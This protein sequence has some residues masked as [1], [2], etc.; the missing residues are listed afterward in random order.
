MSVRGR[1]LRACLFLLTF[2]AAMSLACRRPPALLRVTFL[3]VGQGDATVIE[4]PSGRVLLVDGG[5]VPGTQETA[6][7][8]P[9]VR[10][11]VPF[12]RHR[13]I[14]T[15]DL[16]VA[17]HPDDDHVQGLI[18]VVRQL[19]VRAA[20]D[21]G[22]PEAQGACRRL[23]AAIQARRIPAIPA[24]RGQRFDLG[25]GLWL[26]V[27]HPETRFL[28]GT[29]SDA[30]NNAIV[31]RLRVGRIRILL[32]ADAEAEA[33]ERLVRSGIDLQADLLKVGH[34]GSRG[35]STAAF[36]ERVRPRVAVVSCGRRN[37]FGHPH[38][39]TLE[40]LAARDVHL[41]RTDRDGAVVAETDGRRLRVWGTRR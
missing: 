40:R 29:G 9:G 21:T 6:G 36:L 13:G 22:F 10:A 5:G 3:D 26:D 39:E 37:R 14:S 17:T 34:H 8:D 16:L 38:H 27:L 20:L 19:R 7:R 35:S 15:I 25:G 30:N 33:E 4:C 2:L 24:R 1:W 41:F 23:R 28:A 31:L 11:V 18:A 12:L 32:P